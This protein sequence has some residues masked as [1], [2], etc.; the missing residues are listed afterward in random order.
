MADFALAADHGNTLGS[1]SAEEG[2]FHAS[3]PE[4]SNEI[5]V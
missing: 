2:E 4:S 5:S 1:S 3:F